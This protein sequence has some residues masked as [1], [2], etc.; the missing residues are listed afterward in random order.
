M[1]VAPIP[2]IGPAVSVYCPSDVPYQDEQRRLATIHV[3]Q[4]FR[5]SDGLSAANTQVGNWLLRRAPRWAQPRVERPTRGTPA[6]RR[7]A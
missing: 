7:V 1:A 6:A 4:R 2:G 3:D 5:S